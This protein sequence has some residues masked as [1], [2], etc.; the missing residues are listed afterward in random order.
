[1]VQAR[2]CMTLEKPNGALCRTVP[3]MFGF[4]GHG[5]CIRMEEVSLGDFGIEFAG[6][7]HV[8]VARRATQVVE[9]AS[10]GEQPLILVSDAMYKDVAPLRNTHHE[11]VKTM[12]N[13]GNLD[14][15]ARIDIHGFFP[16]AGP[17]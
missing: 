5:R 3:P 17:S 9:H 13:G 16:S 4:D 14:L 2:V 1:M 11:V 12:K 15:S 6:A 7:I 8:C 10:D